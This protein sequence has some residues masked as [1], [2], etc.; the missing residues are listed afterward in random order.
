VHDPGTF[1]GQ[2]LAGLGCCKLVHIDLPAHRATLGKTTDG[3]ADSTGAKGRASGASGAV[4]LLT[5]W[6]VLM[7]GG[8]LGGAG[9]QLHPVGDPDT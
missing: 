5:A 4:R 6:R 9:F 8:Q 2:A 1:D 3:A 7:L